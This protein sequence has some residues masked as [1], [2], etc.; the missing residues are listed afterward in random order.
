MFWLQNI[1]YCPLEKKQQQKPKKND[2]YQ[3]M[4]N[5]GNLV[6]FLLA[7]HKKRLKFP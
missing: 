1:F 4:M 3:A 6:H 2:I 5:K 7:K